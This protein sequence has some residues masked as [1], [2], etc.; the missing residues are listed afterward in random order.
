MKPAAIHTLLDFEDKPAL[1][2]KKG[3]ELKL[4][5]PDLIELLQAVLDKGVPFRFRAKGFSMTPFIKD[6]DVITIFPLEGSRPR[7]GDIVAFTHPV[8]DEAGM[9]VIGWTRRGLDGVSL[10]VP[11][12]LRRL[13][14]GMQR[15]DI[16]VIHDARPM[17]G[18]VLEG[19]LERIEE[20]GLRC[21]LPDGG[22]VDRPTSNAEDGE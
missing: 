11:A 17:S 18:Q 5:G 2:S 16:L 13:T 20:A 1:F 3:G 9:Q 12:I 21:E 10:D 22:N 14:R 4:S 7:L 15:G 8:T 19:L 6:G